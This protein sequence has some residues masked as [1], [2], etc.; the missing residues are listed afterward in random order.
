MFWKGPTG[1]AGKFSHHIFRNGAFNPIHPEGGFDVFV[2]E[3]N[4]TLSGTLVVVFRLTRGFFLT[5]VALS[6]NVWNHVAVTLEDN[7]LRVYLNATQVFVVATSRY[8]PPTEVIESGLAISAG[9]GFSFNGLIDE[10]EMFIE[11]LSAE[12]VGAIFAAGSAGKC[13]PPEGLTQL[14]IADVQDLVTRGVLQPGPQ[15]NGLTRKL[16]AAIDALERGN[17][18]VAVNKLGDFIKQVQGLVGAGKLPPADGQALIATAQSIIDQL[19]P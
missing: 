12:T 19:S 11:A 2:L 1:A 13:K 6:T 8:V 7:L 10:V 18:R 4:G 9:L 5:G 16:D 3:S 14:L 15:A 17:V